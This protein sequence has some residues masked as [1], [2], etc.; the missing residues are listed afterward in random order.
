MIIA[1]LP[2]VAQQ[3]GAPRIAAPDT[4]MGAA[5]GAPHDTA[6]QHRIL[7]AALEVLDTATTPGELTHIA[8]T[9]R[10]AIR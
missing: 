7:T 10:T 9:Y 5:L 8:E 6:Q 4:P 1:S 3:L 2:A